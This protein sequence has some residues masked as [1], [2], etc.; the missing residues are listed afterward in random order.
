MELVLHA[1]AAS[2]A[3]RSHCLDPEHVRSVRGEVVNLD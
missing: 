3:F 2:V 1:V